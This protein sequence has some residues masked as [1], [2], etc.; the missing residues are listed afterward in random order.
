M[1]AVSWS[2]LSA[3]GELVSS[4]CC[5]VLLLLLCSLLLFLK[6]PP[7]LPNC[8]VWG[9]RSSALARTLPARA[10]GKCVAF[11]LNALQLVGLR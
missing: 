11:V 9:E 1:E 6:T 4:A 3:Y 10:L 5:G 2:F 7:G 8:A